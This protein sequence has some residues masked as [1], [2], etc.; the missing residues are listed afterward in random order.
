MLTR[1]GFRKICELSKHETDPNFEK[2]VNF[3]ILHIVCKG[4]PGPFFLM[5]PPLEPACPPP[6]KIFVSSP[7]FSVPP[8]FKVFQTVPPHETP[9]CPNSTH[10]PSLHKINRFKQISEG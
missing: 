10:Q 3:K 8:L 6:F 4:I 7:V 2:D 5:H 1:K 9:S